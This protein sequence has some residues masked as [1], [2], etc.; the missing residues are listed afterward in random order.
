MHCTDYN[1]LI[2][3][4]LPLF[5][6]AQDQGGQ[7]LLG[8]AAVGGLALLAGHVLNGNKAQKQGW[9]GLKQRLQNEPSSQSSYHV[10]KTV[11]HPAPAP[12]P[13]RPAAPA[14]TSAPKRVVVHNHHH[15]PTTT[16]AKPYRAPEPEV[17]APVP[18][19]YSAIPV[20]LTPDEYSPV[21]SKTPE[22]TSYYTV[23]KTTQKPKYSAVPNPQT[24]TLA[25]QTFSETFPA[26]NP[27]S[28]RFTSSKAPAEPAYYT[29]PKTTQKPKY[30]AVPNPQ[31]TTLAPQFNHRSP[32][33]LSSKI[34]STTISEATLKNLS[35][36]EINT[37]FKTFDVNNDGWISRD[38]FSAIMKIL[39][40]QNGSIIA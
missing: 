4:L 38:E 40:K 6:E 23:P 30:S 20:N 19:K 3:F 35:D 29:V 2:G 32:K 22:R 13:Y 9:A 18:T 34:P 27:R 31:T 17:Y 10:P 8:V 15:Y 33:V 28:V 7:A 39:G 26:I 11:Y 1:N 21:P 25:P 14:P 5:A 16:T 12:A 37:A 36:D 24:T